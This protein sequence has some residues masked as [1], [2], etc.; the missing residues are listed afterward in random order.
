[1]TTATFT[2]PAERRPSR[3]LVPGISLAVGIGAAALSVV[4]IITDDVADVAELPAVVQPDV[5]V[6]QSPT[7]QRQSDTVLAPSS[8]ID[9]PDTCRF[10]RP[11][12]ADRC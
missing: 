5:V 4:A 7:V 6:D 2:Q 10:P 1:M 9:D 8:P 12:P 11:G 3:W